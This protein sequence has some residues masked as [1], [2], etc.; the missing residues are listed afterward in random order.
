M[1]SL[2]K[3]KLLGEINAVPENLLPRFYRIIH[4]LRKELVHP[5]KEKPIRGSLRGI[6]GTVVINESLILEAK[7][8]MFFYEHKEDLNEFRN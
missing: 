3:Q 6:W 2:Y 8:S 1:A 4:A 7:E 5:T